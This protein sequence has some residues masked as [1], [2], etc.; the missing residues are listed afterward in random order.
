MNPEKRT[1]FTEEE[2]RLRRN[3]AS[4]RWRKENYNKYLETHKDW[5]LKNKDYIAKKRS[6]NYAKNK[7][8]IALYSLEYK[9]KNH[10]ALLWRGARLR[11]KKNGREFNIDKSDVI[12][13]EFCPIL[14]VKLIRGR[15]VRSHNSATIDRIDNKKGYIKG[16]IQVISCRANVMKNDASFEEIEK[17]YIYMKQFNN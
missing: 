2:K 15:G 7:D 1:K 8:K 11:A 16:N 10:A 6:E 12:V 14:G 17:L 9:D 3:A 13:P 4:A 5:C